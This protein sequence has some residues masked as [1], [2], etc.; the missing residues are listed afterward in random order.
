[1]IHEENLEGNYNTSY[2]LV[3][4]SPPFL[5]CREQLLIV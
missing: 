4:S 2:Y 1:M 3:F 5:G